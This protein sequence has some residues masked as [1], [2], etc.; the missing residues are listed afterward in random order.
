MDKSDAKSCYNRLIFVYLQAKNI[1][2]KNSAFIVEVKSRRKT[3]IFEA[4]NVTNVIFAGG[5]LPVAA[6]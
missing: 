4:N 5:Y 3:D 1:M 2:N 6:Y